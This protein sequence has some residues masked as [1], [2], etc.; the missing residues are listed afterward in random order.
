[1]ALMYYD[2]IGEKEK[3]KIEKPA[4]ENLSSGNKPQT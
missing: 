4:K 1:M 2:I 3:T